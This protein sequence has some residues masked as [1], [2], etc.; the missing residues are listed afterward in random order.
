MEIMTIK[1]ILTLLLLRRPK[2]MKPREKRLLTVLK[3]VK[4]VWHTAS[5]C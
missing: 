5:D 2:P 3:Q 4:S 1:A